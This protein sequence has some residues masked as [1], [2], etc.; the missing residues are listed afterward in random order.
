M[1]ESDFL[2][3]DEIIFKLYLECLRD[4]YGLV[5]FVIIENL[6]RFTATVLVSGWIDLRKSQEILARTKGKSW[7]EEILK[8]WPKNS[9]LASSIKVR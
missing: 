8:R 6:N 2:F 1:Q 3:S 9:F 4:L 5:A 7:G